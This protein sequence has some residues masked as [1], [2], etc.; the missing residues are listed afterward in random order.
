[1]K[2]VALHEI[3]TT[4]AGLSPYKGSSESKTFTLRIHIENLSNEQAESALASKFRIAWQNANRDKYDQLEDG[5][6][7]DYTPYVKVETVRT[8]TFEEMMKWIEEH[9]EDAKKYAHLFNK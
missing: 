1:M 9:P 7:I 2:Q 6:T 3:I 4:K 8:M 5:S